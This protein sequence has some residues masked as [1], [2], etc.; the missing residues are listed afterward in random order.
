MKAA[1]IPRAAKS[2]R[3]DA[4]ETSSSLPAPFARAQHV[5]P[6]WGDVRR[7]HLTPREREV[8][9]LLCEGLS[10]KLIARRL[11]IS[12]GTVKVHISNV[13]RALNVSTRLQA[14]LLA[15]GAELVPLNGEDTG[16]MPHAL[17]ATHR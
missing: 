3:K 6:P 15:R 9:T 2:V 4:A 1:P 5:A 14:V 12:A 7:V 10:N 16:H 8:L 11:R 13:L 17:H